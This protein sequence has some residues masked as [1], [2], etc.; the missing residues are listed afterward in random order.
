M[1]RRVATSLIVTA[2]MLA[3]LFATGSQPGPAAPAPDKPAPATKK[4]RQLVINAENGTAVWDEATKTLTATHVDQIKLPD[5][6]SVLRADRVVWNREQRWMRATG[7]PRMWD[8]DNELTA[9]TIHADLKAKRATAEGNVRLVAR[10]KKA[11]TEQGQKT[12]AQ[13]E[14]P[15]VVLCDKMDYFYQAKR[16]I[17][18][19]NLKLTQKDK[20]AD[21]TATGERLS[22]DGNEETVVLEGNVHVT[23][24]KGEGFQCKRVVVHLKEGAEGFQAEGI[25]DATFFFTEEE[26]GESTP[27]AAGGSE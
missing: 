14:E 24:T 9:D 25:T 26:E 12:R 7:K 23:N 18:T 27:P 3:A 22:Y 5:S 10:P 13:V 19:G 1:H 16:G 15:V 4:E 6:Q 8:P 17:A 2:G 20:R 11:K 21:R